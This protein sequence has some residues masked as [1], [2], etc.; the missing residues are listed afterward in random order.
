MW[1]VTFEGI[2]SSFIS[3]QISPPDDEAPDLP[4]PIE[5]GNLATLFLRTELQFKKENQNTRGDGLERG[6]SLGELEIAAVS[7]SSNQSEA[8]HR[9]FFI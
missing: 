1:K 5:S 2:R 4:N 7:P 6:S 9:R 3:F 8:K